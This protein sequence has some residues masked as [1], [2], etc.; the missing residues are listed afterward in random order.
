VTRQENTV[1]SRISGKNIGIIAT[2]QSAAKF[3]NVYFEKGSET[4]WMWAFNLKGL[5]YSPLLG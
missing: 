1:N 4:R 2:E 5:R 3:Q